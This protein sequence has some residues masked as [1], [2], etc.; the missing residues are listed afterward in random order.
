MT[1][2]GI[3]ENMQ[4]CGKCEVKNMLFASLAGTPMLNG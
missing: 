1:K 2:M 3:G 4:L